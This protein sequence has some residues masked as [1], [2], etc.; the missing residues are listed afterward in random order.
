MVSSHLCYLSYF[1]L[2]FWCFTNKFEQITFIFHPSLDYVF[3]KCCITKCLIHYENSPHRVFLVCEAFRGIQVI[4]VTYSGHSWVNGTLK[5]T[6]NTSQGDGQVEECRTRMKDW[7][8]KPLQPGDLCQSVLVCQQHCTQKTEHCRGSVC[9]C[10]LYI[11]KQQL[12]LW[13]YIHFLS[14]P[15]SVSAFFSLF[16]STTAIGERSEE[17]AQGAKVAV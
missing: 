13:I 14:I 17:S 3:K 7:E 4:S 6:H 2:L 1:L 8:I 12:T 10:V 5:S 9:V 11:C 15:D 16:S